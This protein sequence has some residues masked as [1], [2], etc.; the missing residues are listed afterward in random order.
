MSRVFRDRQA[1]AKLRGARSKD[2]L[3][4]LL[5]GVGR[6]RCRLRPAAGRGPVA[7]RGH[8]RA[9]ESLYRHARD[10][11]PVRV[12]DRDRR[13]W[14][15]PH[16]LRGRQDA[17]IHAAGAAH[18][19][20]YFKMMDDAAFYAC[21]SLV[22][23]RFLLTTAFNLVFTRPLKRGRV[24]AEGAGSA[25]SAGCS[26]ARPAWSFADGEEAARGT[27]TF[28]RSHIPLSSLPGYRRPPADGAA[29][30][31][32][33]GGALLRRAEA[34]GGFGAV[35]AKGD[36]T[37]G[38]IAVILAEKGE[39]IRVPG[40]PAAA[41]RSLCLARVGAQRRADAEDSRPCS[42]GAGNPT[43]TSGSWNWISRP[44][45]GSPLK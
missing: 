34:E 10:Q 45:N 31:R 5:A 9:L 32:G 8:F 38:A 11:P 16:P 12:R 28:M 42:R 35:L 6:A 22:S 19:T 36:P 39:E 33:A 2:A 30:Q 14:L 24:V 41:G 3:F 13:A 23:D 37:A 21:N 43:P 17:P 20:L 27:G 1:V 7:G 40:A 15:R 4:A 26:S 25:A 44:P 29:G 18:G